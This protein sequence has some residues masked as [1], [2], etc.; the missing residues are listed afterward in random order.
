M[1]KQFIVKAC[2]LI[3]DSTMKYD[4]ITQLIDE[5]LLHGYGNVLHIHKVR[6]SLFYYGD[7]RRIKESENKPQCV[8]QKRTVAYCETVVTF[9]VN[10]RKLKGW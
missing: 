8:R 1:D 10:I 4:E 6:Q 7:N 9:C 2:N 3:Q 5:S